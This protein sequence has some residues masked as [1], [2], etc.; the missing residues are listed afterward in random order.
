M[1]ESG[2]TMDAFVQRQNVVVMRIGK[3][4]VAYEERMIR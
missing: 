2:T 4:G 1:D 3:S